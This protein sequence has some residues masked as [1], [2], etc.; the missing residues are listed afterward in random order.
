MIAARSAKLGGVLPQRARCI[1]AIRSASEQRVGMGRAL[2]H[3]AFGDIKFAAT[4][5][6]DCHLR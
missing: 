3:R 1:E 2:C 5:A 6:V 4:S